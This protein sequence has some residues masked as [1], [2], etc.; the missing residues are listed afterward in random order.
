MGGGE[1]VFQEW[2]ITNQLQERRELKSVRKNMKVSER[3]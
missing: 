1:D 2:I 3:V